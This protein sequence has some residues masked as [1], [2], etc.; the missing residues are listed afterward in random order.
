MAQARTALI[1]GEG[2]SRPAWTGLVVTWLVTGFPAS[3]SAGSSASCAI[4]QASIG[5]DRTFHDASRLL[6]YACE[7]G[8][9]PRLEVGCRA[10]AMPGAYGDHA[11]RYEVKAVEETQDLFPGVD[12]YP[13]GGVGEVKFSPSDELPEPTEM[14]R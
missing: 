5:Y 10:A 4:W 3:L 2:R 6:G 14:I 9:R 7:E 13:R 12:V 8:C 11:R 1:S